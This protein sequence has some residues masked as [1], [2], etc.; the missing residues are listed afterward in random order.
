MRL[1]ICIVLAALGCSK[2]PGTGHPDTTGR[3]PGGACLTEADCPPEQWCL[4]QRCSD[5]PGAQEPPGSDAHLVA[6]PGTL[7]FGT[8]AVGES[9]TLALVLENDGGSFVSIARVT[10]DAAPFT[11]E[12]MGYGPFWIRPE[13]TRELFVTYTPTASGSH[14]AT[15]TI[16][17]QA[18]PVTVSLLGN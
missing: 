4:H 8:V 1:L 12:S 14:E 5:R 3:G 17:S 10:V 9:Q 2:D 15:L 11:V 7:H 13:R 6:T 16:H 18:P